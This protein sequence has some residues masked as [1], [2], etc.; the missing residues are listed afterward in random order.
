MG[1]E[2]EPPPKPPHPNTIIGEQVQTRP[3]PSNLTLYPTRKGRPRG[4]ARGC[5]PT[6][7]VKKLGGG[8]LGQ[9]GP[10]ETTRHMGGGSHSP[11]TGCK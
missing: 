10:K 9:I 8:L 6:V 1:G 2:A 3:N 4:F 11:P 5:I 7:F